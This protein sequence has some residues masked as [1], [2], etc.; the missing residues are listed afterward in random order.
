[1]RAAIVGATGLVGQKMREILEER[2]FPLSD[3]LLLAT[4]RSEGLAVPFHGQQLEVQPLSEE[5]LE[6]IDFALFAVQADVSR[7]MAP[8]AV[9][10]GA[11]VIDN[12]SAFRLVPQIPLVVP[13][14][15]PRDLPPNPTIIANPNCSTIQLVVAVH[16]LH[17]AARIR[18]MIVDTY[19]S[20]SGTGRAGWEELRDQSLAT[21]RGEQVK[22]LAY[23]HPMAFNLFP[24]IGEFDQDGRSKEEVKIVE[25]TRKILH[26]DRLQI[27][28]TTV[29]VPV[30]TGHAEAVHLEFESELSPAEARD[31]LRRAPGVTVVDDPPQSLYPTPLQA[32][33]GDEVF[34]GR[35]RV[36]PSVKHGLS[37]WVVAD[38]LR[39]GAALNAVQIAEMVMERRR[40]EGW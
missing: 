35:I 11:V 18:R 15:N 26:E 8:A 33:G 32:A 5:R 1:M 39:K 9:E 19:Q 40:E 38:N 4:E 27:A 23:P 20:V 10:R 29:R 2:D 12:S 25:E 21:L 22:V 30:F 6:D 16:P 3:L 37:L 31:I 14:V 7:A 17:Q 24:H 34:I 13:E 28:V 36:D